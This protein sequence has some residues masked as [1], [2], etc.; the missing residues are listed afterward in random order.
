MGTR[1]RIER[2]IGWAGAAAACLVLVACAHWRDDFLD[3]GINKATKEEVREKFGPPHVAKE[4]LLGGESTWSYR[5]I[6]TDTEKNPYSMDSIT[7]PATDLGNQAAAL[8]GKGGQGSSEKLH[9]VRYILTFTPG[10]VLKDWRREDCE[11]PGGSAGQ[12]SK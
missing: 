4:S 11:K 9:C 12:A 7:R 5:F 1:M 2:M 10:N 8:I 3:K 6:L